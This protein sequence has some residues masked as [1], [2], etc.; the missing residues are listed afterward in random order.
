MAFPV[1]EM[2]RGS[3]KEVLTGMALKFYFI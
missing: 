1:F 3:V 2:I